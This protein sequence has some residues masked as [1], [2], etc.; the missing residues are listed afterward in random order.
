MPRLLAVVSAAALFG[1]CLNKSD[2]PGNTPGAPVPSAKGSSALIDTEWATL[3]RKI[4]DLYRTGNYDR[5]VTVAK[6]SLELAAKNAGPDHPDVATSL[7]NMALLFR[8]TNRKQE[9]EKLEQRAAR[10]YAGAAQGMQ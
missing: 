3:N 9:A 1:G 6:Q 10:I 5:A 8:A 7:E 2:S 4:R